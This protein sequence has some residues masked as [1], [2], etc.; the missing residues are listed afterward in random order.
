MSVVNI[1]TKKISDLMSR[2]I[3]T[4]HVKNSFTHTMRL[5]DE[6]PFHHLPIVNEKTKLIGILSSNDMLKALTRQTV[7]LKEM[8]QENLNAALD[9][10]EIMTSNPITISP[11]STIKEAIAIFCENE[12]HALP[13]VKDDNLVGIITSNDLLKNSY[14]FP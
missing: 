10:S 3:L 7:L 8:N 4:G 6:M 11:D 5:F 12:I 2:N 13:V 14:R 9:I 1:K